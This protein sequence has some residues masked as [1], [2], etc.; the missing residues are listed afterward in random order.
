MDEALKSAAAAA[1][2]QDWGLQLT[3]SITEEELLRLLEEKV[4][5]IVQ[6]GTDAFYRLMYRVDIPEKK[7]GAIIGTPDISARIARMIYERQLQKLASR[8]AYNRR[9][10]I[11]DD[12]LKW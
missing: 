2:Q 9:D 4:I 10:I 12:D 7:I 1:L 6:Q 5:A 8:K 3:P 11:E